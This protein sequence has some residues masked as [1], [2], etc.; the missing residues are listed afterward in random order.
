MENCLAKKPTGTLKTWT[1]VGIIVSILFFVCY[2]LIDVSYY[3]AYPTQIA[4]PDFISLFLTFNGLFATAA[5]VFF[6]GLFAAKKRNFFIKF[7]LWAMALT[8]LY[9]VMPGLSS[10]VGFFGTYS[11]YEL[12]YYVGL[13]L[14]QTLVS[15]LL[16]SAIIQ[17][18]CENNMTTN[19]IAWISIVADIV[20][21]VFQ[22]VYVFVQPPQSADMSSII[23]SLAG[24]IAIAVIFCL[25][26]VILTAT[27][28]PEKKKKAKKLVAAAALDDLV[29]KIVPDDSKEVKTAAKKNAGKKE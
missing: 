7:M 15:V 23:I 9:F 20:L 28:P 4:V 17:K 19:T 11:S 13:L 24:A 26:F 5:I 21:F 16:V 22:I 3:Q 27:T 18:D 12:L 10:L 1:I 29:E 6:I 25:S 2:V 8:G 14:P